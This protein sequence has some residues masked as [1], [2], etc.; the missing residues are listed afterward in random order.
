LDIGKLALQ[1]ILEL[2]HYDV[3]LVE[4]GEAAEPI[5]EG[6]EGLLVWV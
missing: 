5:L 4:S 6:Q 3:L 1:A 2:N